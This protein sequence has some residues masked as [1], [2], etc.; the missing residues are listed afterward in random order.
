MKQVLTVAL[1][2]AL[3]LVASQGGWFGPNDYDECI[4]E[5]MKGVT[6]DVAARLIRRS[7]RDKFPP[8]AKKKPRTKS[9]TYKELGQLTGKSWFEF[10]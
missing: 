1:C 8:Q 2:L 3:I 10:R 9:L 4:L 7:C 6:S 5:S